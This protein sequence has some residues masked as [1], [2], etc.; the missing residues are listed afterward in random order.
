MKRFTSICA[1]I[2]IVASLCLAVGDPTSKTESDEKKD[3][4][5]FQ[6]DGTNILRRVQYKSED[7]AKRILRQEILIG[8]LKVAEIVDFQG[9]H[10]CNAEAGLP[11]TVGFEHSPTGG[12]K[13]VV[14][15][16]DDNGIVEA[17][18]VAD[19]KLIPVSGEKLDTAREFTKDFSGFIDAVKEKEETPEELKGR[20]VNMLLKAKI[21]EQMHNKASEDTS[22]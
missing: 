6:R 1:G 10:T 7:P 9:T 19:G 2:V 4:I 22:Q 5:T 13:N 3:T 17:Y 8:D 16:D 11:V 12:L 14:L 18:D 21:K 20:V 15:M